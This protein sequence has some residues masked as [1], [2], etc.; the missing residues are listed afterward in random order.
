MAC[1]SPGVAVP[2]IGASGMVAGVTLLDGADAA[3]GPVAL[4]ATTVNVYAMPL[5]KPV[6]TIGLAVPVAV[7]PPGDDVTVYDVTGVPPF[8]AGAVKLTVAWVFPRTADT[9]VG[10]PGTILGVT[11][12]DGADA[13]PVPR[14][15]VAVTVNV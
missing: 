6:T 3:P 10:A 14:A 5:V 8:G 15:F 11:L 12:L 1:V 13:A 7:M 2:I 9:A 4:A